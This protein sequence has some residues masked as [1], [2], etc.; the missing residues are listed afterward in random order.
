MEA[1]IFPN[2]CKKEKQ[3]A[4]Y[5][6]PGKGTSTHAAVVVGD[7]VGDPF[8][9]HPLILCSKCPRLVCIMRLMLLS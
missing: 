3:Y 4:E 7:T 5:T 6:T 2:P 9:V 1:S 8:K